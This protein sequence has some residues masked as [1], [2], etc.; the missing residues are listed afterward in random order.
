MTDYIYRV[1]YRT[2]PEF[3][4]AHR[5]PAENKWKV[6]NGRSY[7]N[8]PT[9][10]GLITGDKRYETSGYPDWTPKHEYDIQRYPMTQQWEHIDVQGI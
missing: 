8:L 7:S 9:V 1:L 4:P 6:L 5:N 10:K 2:K 3:W